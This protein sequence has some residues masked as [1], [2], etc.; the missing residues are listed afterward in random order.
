MNKG[1]DG[2]TWSELEEM[3]QVLG[4]EFR[5][6]SMNEEDLRKRLARLGFNATEI[7][8]YVEEARKPT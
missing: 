5:E 1:Q 8:N 7:D 6:Q 3:I 2:M 4:M